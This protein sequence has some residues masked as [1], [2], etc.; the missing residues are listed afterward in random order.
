MASKDDI[1]QIKSEAIERIGLADSLASLKE[2]R[3]RYLGRKGPVMAAL[4]SLGTLP[5]DQ[6]K[7]IGALT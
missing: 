3:V 5:P 6:R 4:K 2:L 1:A 7:E